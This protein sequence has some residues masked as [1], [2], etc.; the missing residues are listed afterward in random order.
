M[1]PGYIVSLLLT[2]V[3]KLFTNIV[4]DSAYEE[5]PLATMSS[6]WEQNY[7]TAHSGMYPVENTI[8]RKIMCLSLHITEHMDVDF[9]SPLIIHIRILDVCHITENRITFHFISFLF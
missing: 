4:W 1:S 5:A 3:T 7:N 9:G 2:S 6:L 8:R